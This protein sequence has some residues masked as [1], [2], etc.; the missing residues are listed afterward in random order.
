MGVANV[1]GLGAAV[2]GG[3]GSAKASK[4]QAKASA[5]QLGWEKQ[6]YR[7]GKAHFTG[8]QAMADASYAG[9]LHQLA[10]SSPAYGVA[11]C[12]AASLAT[13]YDAKSYDM[14]AFMA[15][16]YQVELDGFIQS[17]K[18]A[19]DINNISMDTFSR[20][21]GQIMDNVKQNILNVSQERLSATGREQLALD[22]KTLQQNFD[23][24]MSAKGMGRSG[25]TVESHAR[26]QMEVNKQ[27]R[28][29][30]VNSYDQANQLQSMGVQ[31]LNSMTQGEQSIS[32]RAEQLYQNKAHGLLQAGM[33]DANLKTQTSLQNANN[34]TLASRTNAQSKTQV[35]LANA[36]N[37]TNVSMTNATNRT[38]VSI[39]NSR[40]ATNVSMANAGITNAKS[41]ALANFH[42]SNWARQQNAQNSFYSGNP[43]AG[44]SAA[45]G[46]QAS[47]A[48]QDAAGWGKVAG[49]GAEKAYDAW[50]GTKPT[51][52]P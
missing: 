33:Q 52:T 12:A 2:I 9:A 5:A 41:M 45:Y 15:D 25:I 11:S 10:G 13:A 3:I 18:D 6:M 23:H 32:Q 4:A 51:T 30:D 46:Q 50:A 21:Y 17:F 48:G 43:G 20:R 22:A 29:I 34:K 8:G 27:A 36:Q 42:N 47:Q 26:M 40:N 7:E 24:E 1:I 14:K 39:N 35:S 38:N 19:E 28:A 31:T 44:V 37:K 16:S 49:W